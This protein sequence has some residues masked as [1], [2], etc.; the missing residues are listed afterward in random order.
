MMSETPSLKYLVPAHAA[1]QNTMF[2]GGQTA[3]VSGGH[4]PPPETS[5]SPAAAMR[6]EHRYVL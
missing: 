5:R 4:P 3:S 6:D 2:N 1:E